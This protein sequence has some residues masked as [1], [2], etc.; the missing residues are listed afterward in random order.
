MNIRLTTKLTTCSILYKMIVMFVKIIF[1]KSKYGL[2]FKSPT[3][4][5][6]KTESFFNLFCINL[7]V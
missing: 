5:L 4:L 1:N 6:P 3:N 2:I 7:I